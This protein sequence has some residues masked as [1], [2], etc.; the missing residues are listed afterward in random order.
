MNYN[1]EIQKN[2][3]RLETVENYHDKIQILKHAILIADT[4]QDIDWGFDLRLNLIHQ[5]RNTSSCNESF[6]AFAWILNASDSNEGYFDES[7]FLWEYK[8]MFNSSYRNASISMEQI[9][10]I[11]EDLKNRLLKNGYSLRGFYN[12]MTGLS[13]HLRDFNGAQKYIDL[14]NQSISDDMTNCQACELDTEVDNLLRLGQMERAIV[15]AKS[16]FDRKITCYSMPFQTYCNF[17]YRLQ[18]LN[19]PLA[20]QY[21]EKALEEYYNFDHYDSSIGFSMNQLVSYM[22]K[23]NHKDKWLFFEK[24]SDWELDAEDLHIFNYT[25]SM[26]SIMQQ[27]GQIELSLSCKLPYYQQDG[28][29]NIEDLYLYFEQ[30]ALH[31]AGLFD[32][33]NSN[34][35]FIQEVS[36]LQK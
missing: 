18:E 29:Y 7:D 17:A 10:E 14:A 28:I 12:V 16:I 2:L 4:H 27:S 9:N 23:S 34:S 32:Q 19:D 5:E 6:V 31:Y 13:T 22:H 25:K 11:G 36:Q 30:K 15:A 24:I 20:E 33:R 3:L 8:W 21:F 1:L 35:N 26:M